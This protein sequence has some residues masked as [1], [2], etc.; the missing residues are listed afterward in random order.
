MLNYAT[1]AAFAQSRSGATLQG[2]RLSMGVAGFPKPPENMAL[3]KHMALNLMRSTKANARL[4]VRRK[5]AAWNTTYLSQ[6]LR[7]AA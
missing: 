2:N 5:K 6:V 4:K 1:A 3:V 7:G